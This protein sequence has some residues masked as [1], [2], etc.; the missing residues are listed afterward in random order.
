[1]YLNASVSSAQGAARALI[2]GAAAVG[3]VRSEF[4]HPT[5]A[6]IPDNKFYRQAFND[7]CA[8][9]NPLA[10]TIRLL[11]L[12]PDKKPPWL[13]S[14]PEAQVPTGLQG[15]RL[16]QYEPVDQVVRAQ[17]TAIA[18]LADEYELRLLIPYVSLPEEYRHCRQTIHS[19]IAKPLAVGAMLETPAAVLDIGYWVEHADFVGIGCND[20]MQNLF[21]AD[22]DSPQLKSYLNPYSPA[23]LRLL[24]QTARSAGESIGKIQ[25]CGL[26]PQWPGILP[27]L[28]G[29]GF[30]S[31]SIEPLK[32]PYLAQTA[33]DTSTN[34]LQPVIDRACNAAD[35]HEVCRILNVPV[36]PDS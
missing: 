25:L 29:M 8:A 16:Y 10:I 33:I 24:R 36:W 34:K 17:L 4:L 7:I 28:I 9:S 22:R 31:F 12:A 21:A 11:D 18:P 2:N 32:I 26:L 27:L 5:D 6:R 35:A 13:H 30:V 1:M 15:V 3:L 20:L 19:V 23:L 14:I